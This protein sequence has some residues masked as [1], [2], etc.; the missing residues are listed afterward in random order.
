MQRI[1]RIRQRAEQRLHPGPGQIRPGDCRRQA[2]EN[3]C[4]VRPIGRS[5]TVQV[6]QQ[7]QP[8]GAGGG[9]Q[10]QLAELGVVDPQQIADDGEHP[11]GVDRGDQR[12][13]STGRVGEPG[14]RSGRVRHRSVGHAEG[15]AGGADG[16][17]HI[18]V[19]EPESQCRCHVVTSPRAEGGAGWGSRG[20]RCGRDDRRQ[21]DLRVTGRSTER[22][23]GQFGQPLP[24]SRRVIPGPRR[25]AVIGGHRSAGAVPAGQFPGEPVVW[26]QD[27]RCSGCIIRL[28]FGQPAEL[29][30][31]ERRGRD[32]T[33]LVGAPLRAAQ[34]VDHLGDLW[35]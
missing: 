14:H 28:V 11:R 3:P 10:C 16:D 30:D 20:H 18:A 29:G 35:R 2:L 17:G 4:R 25:V 33:N 5:F 13:V 19:A 15:G 8:A 31:G 6:G 1:N 9:R 34:P 7:G 23:L 24:A 27:G 26:Q 21:G 12:Q 32:R 22:P